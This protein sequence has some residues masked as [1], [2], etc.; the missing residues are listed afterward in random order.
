MHCACKTVQVGFIALYG[1]RAGGPGTK[2]GSMLNGDTSYQGHTRRFLSHGMSRTGEAVTKESGLVVAGR[3][4]MTA[5]GPRD[6]G[7]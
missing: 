1:L 2:Q 3:R 7:V 4:L 5:N 6:L